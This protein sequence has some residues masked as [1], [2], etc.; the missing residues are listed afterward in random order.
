MNF[1]SLT[2]NTQFAMCL[3]LGIL[4]FSTIVYFLL[5]RFGAPK[6]R[7]ELW[8]R[9]RS[10]W[11]IIALVF[12]VLLSSFTIEI[13]FFGL[14]SYLALK[15]FVSI[16]PSRQ[17][18]RR[19]I[20]LVYLAI[21]FQ[22]YWIYTQWFGMFIIFI[23]V[24]LY[25]I[26]ATRLVLLGQTEGFI[27]AASTLHWGAMLCIFS[28]SHLAYLLALPAEG[29]PVGGGI[30]LVLFILFTTQFNDV[31]QYVWGKLLGKHKITPKVSPNK[32][33]EGFL[34]G[35]MTTTLVGGFLAPFLTPFVGIHAFL[36]AA[37]IA[38]AG[39]FGDLTLSAVKR[40][41]GVK[42][43]SQ[44]IPGHGGI[45]DRLDSLSFSAPLFFH[46]LYYLY[47]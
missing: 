17:I 20:F 9:I 38:F 26:L 2:P 7:T 33:W 15:E 1:Y 41:V 30:G 36:V 18:D 42:D 22:Y 47:Y 35:F 43:M 28:L 27:R 4:L 19:A 6:D 45:L 3:I 40:D 13:Y 14:L 46:Y 21:P 24:Y 5:N 8:L 31:L 29:N 34:G 37:L 11:I 44:L 25:F 12:A 23:P 32:T 10:W 16:V 39:F